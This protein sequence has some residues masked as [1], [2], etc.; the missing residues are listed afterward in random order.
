MPS[1]IGTPIASCH[2]VSTAA[3][4]GSAAEMHA[5]TLEKSASWD[6]FSIAAYSAGTEKNNVGCDRRTVSKIRSGVARPRPSTAR[7]PA[8]SGNE[9][10]LPSP[11]AWKD[12]V[13]E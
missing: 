5:R 13:V 12:L 10:E 8:D 6:A 11:Y 3:G 9:S 2:R 1:R 7:A 4:S